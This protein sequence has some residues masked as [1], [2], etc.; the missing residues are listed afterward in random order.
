[1]DSQT[2]PQHQPPLPQPAVDIESRRAQVRKEHANG[3]KFIPFIK[4]VFKRFGEDNAPLLAA[5]LSFFTLISLVPILLVGVSVLT[6]MLR[7]MWFTSGSVNAQEKIV[8][9]A[10]DF[11]PAMSSSAPLQ[12]QLIEF[13]HSLIS[14][15]GNTAVGIIGL[16][17]LIWSASALFLNMEVA[18]N[19]ALQIQAKR[20]F[21]KARLV[22]LGTMALLAVLLIGSLGISTAM[23]WAKAHHYDLPVFTDVIGFLIPIALTFAMF[24]AIYKIVPNATVNNKAVLLGAAF[25]SVFFE[26]AKRGF[27]WYVSHFGNF[28]KLYGSLGIIVFLVTWVLY[29]FMILMVGAEVADVYSDAVLKDPIE[30]QEAD[31]TPQ[32]K[33]GV[34]AQAQ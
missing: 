10:T 14:R 29:S 3:I 22:A 25:S 7:A 30:H 15:P 16:V 12:K 9:A 24:A 21:I 18:L 32:K 13:I 28:D 8:N 33:P 11:F 5:A 2:L 6:Y 26:A 1:M 17:G 27:G 23:S 20:N 19:A 31:S 4:E 34:P